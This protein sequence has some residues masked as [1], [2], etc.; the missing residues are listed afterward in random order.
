MAEPAHD[1]LVAADHLLTVDA[2]VL[3]FL[4]RPLGNGQA[5]GDQRRHIARPAVLDRQ[6]AEV[7]VV[8][9][10]DHFLTGRILEHL[11]RHGQHLA[12]DRQLGPGVLESLGRLRLLEE[13]QQLA[14]LAQLGH[15]FGAH[16]Q[17][18]APRRAEQVAEHRH[19]EAGGVLEQ[20]RRA[21]LAQGAV[22][23]FGHFQHGGDRRL[24]A[25]QFAARLQA[26]NEFAQVAIL[27]A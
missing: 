25:L 3:A 17:R 13:G 5:P 18:H 21:A 15:L 10:L 19:L 14:D 20:Q 23:D 4:V 12:E 22:A 6:L 24:D 1:Q 9:R 26:A 27:H 16:A 11:G 8:A 7:D 2:E